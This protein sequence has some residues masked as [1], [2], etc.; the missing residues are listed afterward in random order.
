MTISLRSSSSQL[1]KIFLWCSLFSMR[2]TLKN[3]DNV[4]LYSCFMKNAILVV[5]RCCSC[6]LETVLLILNVNLINWNENI[7]FYDLKQKLTKEFIWCS[8]DRELIFTFIKTHLFTC[9]SRYIYYTTIYHSRRV[10]H[11]FVVVTQLI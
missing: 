2:R 3:D 4:S 11:I 8:R 5:F 7:Q 10:C 9:I 6:C 1:L